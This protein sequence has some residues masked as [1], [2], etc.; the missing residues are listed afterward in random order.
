MRKQLEFKPKRLTF[1]S[2]EEFLNDPKRDKHPMAGVIDILKAP[3]TYEETVEEQ[4]A[5]IKDLPGGV[6]IDRLPNKDELYDDILKVRM[7]KFTK[8]SQ[9]PKKIMST[10]SMEFDQHPNV[11]FHCHLY[12]NKEF[13]VIIENQNYK[14]M[15]RE[16]EV[17]AFLYADKEFV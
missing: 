13:V 8:L 12:R 16:D 15:T 2:Y 14:G 3:K 10:K 4:Y 11:N 1:D 17:L 6:R 7:P 9:H 5:I